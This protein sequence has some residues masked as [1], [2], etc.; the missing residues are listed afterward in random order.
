MGTLRHTDRFA[1]FMISGDIMD[2]G[3]CSGDDAMRMRVEE[4]AFS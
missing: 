2:R 4:P 3:S 1:T